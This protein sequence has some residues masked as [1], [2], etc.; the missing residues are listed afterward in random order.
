MHARRAHCYFLCLFSHD[1]QETD[2]VVQLQEGGKL[3]LSWRIIYGSVKVETRPS[4]Q[5]FMAGLLQEASRLPLFILADCCVAGEAVVA[6]EQTAVIAGVPQAAFADNVQYQFR[7]EN[8]GGQVRSVSAS[9]Q[10]CVCLETHT[11]TGRNRNKHTEASKT[12]EFKLTS[13][14]L[15]AHVR[16]H[17]EL[18]SSSG[19][20]RLFS[21]ASSPGD[22]PRGSGNRRPAGSL[23]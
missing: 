23:G 13:S 22:L 4:T 3:L 18:C 2:E 1:K 7:T 11:E 17:V 10:L 5:S 9:Q 16:V 20:L 21:C 14:S 15:R 19:L 12:P 8:N 6:D